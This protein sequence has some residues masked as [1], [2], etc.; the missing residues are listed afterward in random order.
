MENELRQKLELLIIKIDDDTKEI[1]E[2]NDKIKANVKGNLVLYE[3]K[4]LFNHIQNLI[5]KLT[6]RFNIL[7]FKYFDYKKYYDLTNIGI[8][9]ISTLLT[10][11]ESVK[12][13]FKINS[14]DTLYKVFNL[15][16]IICSSIIAISA[17]LLKFKKYQEKM[18][19][20][21]KAISSAIKIVYN[22]EKIKEQ[23]LLC[24]N[25]KELN[26]IK[27]IYIKKY[28]EYIDTQENIEKLLKYKDLVKHMQNYY[29]LNLRY[30]KAYTN[31]NYNN[32]KIKIIEEMQTDT[33]KTDIETGGIEGQ[34]YCYGLRCCQ[35]LKKLFK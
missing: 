33:I 35:K 25:I 29:K 2:K 16:P 17:S 13:I 12:N 31:Y 14:D 34:S 26:K 5:D 30:K 11:I 19:N 20:I 1:F 28:E 8:I 21:S 24:N 15:L 4:E 10:I 7:D 23:I 3:K 18:E 32:L 6:I 22:F 27:S 9:I